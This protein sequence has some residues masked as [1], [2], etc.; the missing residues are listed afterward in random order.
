MRTA[1]LLSASSDIGSA[2]A[3]DWLA[4]GDRVVG[5]ERRTSDATAALTA[6]GAMMAPCDLGDRASC[7]A[8]IDFARRHAP[9]WD[10]LVLAAG[11]LDPVGP[12]AGCDFDAWEDSF[13]VNLTAQLRV[14]HGLLP[15]RRRGGEPPLVLF[16]A[17]GGTN[18]AP[19]NFSAY[20]L[21]KIASI[22]MVEL[23][24][25]ELPDV[26]TTILGPGWVRTKIH[27]QTLAAGEHAGAAY[28]QT[29]QRLRDGD[30]IAMERIVACCNWLI[31]QPR[32]V[33]GGRN[34]SAAHDPWG[35]PEL[36][37]ALR[38]DV[39]AYKLRRSGNA[40]FAS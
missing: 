21:A 5:S 8:F 29:V 20:T 24:D 16:F 22:K 6:R 2:L 40:L 39:D 13:T 34:F 3:A 33:I 9:D 27:E 38:A 37:Q 7:E 26:R 1:V 36:A 35:K 10:V 17:G 32:E 4:R 12:F 14:L 19:T 30:F 31:E 28:A 23:L 25:A 11:Q 18:G 15:V